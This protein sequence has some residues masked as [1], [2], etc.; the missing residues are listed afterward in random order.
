MRFPGGKEKKIVNWINLKLSKP[1]NGMMP[2]L[3]KQVLGFFFFKFPYLK[4][5]L[6]NYSDFFFLNVMAVNFGVL[7]YD[8]AKHLESK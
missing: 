8:E 1:F 3:E 6:S 2:E 4:V 5:V 7:W